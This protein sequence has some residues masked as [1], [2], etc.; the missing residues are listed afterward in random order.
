MAVAEK[1]VRRMN[2]CSADKISINHAIRIWHRLHNFLFD[3]L[4]LTT[5]HCNRSP[6]APAPSCQKYDPWKQSP[7]VCISA[8]IIGSRKVSPVEF[9][10]L[11]YCSLLPN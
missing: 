1:N 5:Q 3:L 9:W 2:K 6:F 10:L 4:M 11:Y 7:K 8:Y